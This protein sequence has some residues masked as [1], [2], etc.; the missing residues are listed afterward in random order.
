[1]STIKRVN[2][3]D[4]IVPDSD[5]TSQFYCNVFGFQREGEDEGGGHTS[6]HI[7]DGTE[8]V[9][10]ICADA[11]FPNWLRGWIP[12][13]DVEDY[14]HSVSQIRD[15]GGQVHQEMTMNFNWVGQRFCLAIDPSG[16]PVMVCE[17]AHKN[18]DQQDVAPNA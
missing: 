18:E 2:W 8:N 4:M 3:I 9:L 17:A 12:Y 11:V 6:Y 16:A 14:D 13:I 10:G 15:S 1:M 7:K 5:T